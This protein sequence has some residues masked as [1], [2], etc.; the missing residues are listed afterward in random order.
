MEK[1][2]KIIIGL[3]VVIVIIGIIYVVFGRKNTE[4][5]TGGSTGGT[6]GSTGGTGSN[7]GNIS[8]VESLVDARFRIL[9]NEVP[10]SITSPEGTI[11]MRPRPDKP[12]LEYFTLRDIG[13]GSYLL[14]RA[15]Q[16]SFIFDNGKYFTRN[17]RERSAA[18]SD[19]RFHWKLVSCS[20]GGFKLQSATSGNQATVSGELVVMSPAGTCFDIELV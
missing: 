9:H 11:F 18:A 6:G 12:H 3:L 20:G 16:E 8:V 10:M 13:G 19:P 7:T 14:S 15:N 1:S 4:G 17:N 5:G 2:N